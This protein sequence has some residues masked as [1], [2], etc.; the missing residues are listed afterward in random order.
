MTAPSKREGA[1][2]RP[3]RWYGERRGETEKQH[4]IDIGVDERRREKTQKGRDGLAGD[5]SGKDLLA[6]G[7]WK[8][9]FTVRP[10]GGVALAGTGGGQRGVD[11]RC[12]DDGS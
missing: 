5:P 2:G 9:F 12:A 11:C 3:A 4:E 7:R 10:F 1:G 8:R 6:E